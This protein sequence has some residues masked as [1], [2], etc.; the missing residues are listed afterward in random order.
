MKPT[1]LALVV[2]LASALSPFAQSNQP[3]TNAAAPTA[4]N[5]TA[6]SQTLNSSTLANGQTN[7][8]SSVEIEALLKYQEFLRM[9]G[10]DYL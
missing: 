8:A 9:A 10:P 4:T 2:L 3:P 1:L 5:T 6:S 7:Q